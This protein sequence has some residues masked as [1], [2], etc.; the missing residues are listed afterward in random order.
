MNYILFQ[1]T[2]CLAYVRID[3]VLKQ[4]AMKLEIEQT[5]IFFSFSKTIFIDL[6]TP[7][8]SLSVLGIDREVLKQ[9]L[10]V[11]LKILRLSEFAALPD[12]GPAN[13]EYSSCICLLHGE[14]YS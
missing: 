11:I 2:H 7:V 6:L 10:V 5:S 14:C 12:F 9:F 13:N 4:E 8:S 1:T 3:F